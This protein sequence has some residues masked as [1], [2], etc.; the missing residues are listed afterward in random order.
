MTENS[1]GN[2]INLAPA[3]QGR[4]ADLYKAQAVFNKRVICALKIF[5]FPVPP[6][7]YDLRRALLLE[8]A[9]ACELYHDNIVRAFD[10]G[11]D[12]GKFYLAMDFIT[13]ETLENRLRAGPFTPQQAHKLAADVAAALSYA[14]HLGLPHRNLIARNILFR[15]GSRDAKICDFHLHK[16]TAL[17]EAAAFAKTLPPDRA[18][19]AYTPPEVLAGGEHTARSDIYQ[20]GAL[21]YAALA[22]PQPFKTER[23]PLIGDLR[24]DIGA[25]FETLIT[26]CLA[27]K[28]ERR[29]VSARAIIRELAWISPAAARPR[30]RRPRAGDTIRQRVAFSH[31]NF[32]PQFHEAI[33]RLQTFMLRKLQPAPPPE[34][35]YTTIFSETGRGAA[36]PSVPEKA[37]AVYENTAITRRTQRGRGKNVETMPFLLALL[38]L[39]ILSGYWYF[40]PQPKQSF[41]PGLSGGAQ[42]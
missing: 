12:G 19:Q 36:E 32:P 7:N 27:K 20:F 17:P 16:I 21:L 2:Y 29:P 13:G 1:I 33:V 5:K 42:P 4:Y 11:I 37:A 24:P 6:H 34:N 22:Q 9:A 28:P 26:K 31:D 3:A 40:R 14:H 41:S 15:E 30:Q 35:T 18:Q 10:Y 23:R 39:C 8:A 25:E 38:L